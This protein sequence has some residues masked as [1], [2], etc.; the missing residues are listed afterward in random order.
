MKTSSTP[1][2]DNLIIEVFAQVSIGRLVA[3]SATL[4]KLRW[5]LLAGYPHC[6][7]VTAH[8]SLEKRFNSKSSPK[9]KDSG[10]KFDSP[11]NIQ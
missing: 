4:S 10:L 6:F 3:A 9:Q 8:K 2:K 7:W 11:F 1:I 5:F